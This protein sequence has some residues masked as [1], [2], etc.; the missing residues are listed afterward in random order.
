MSLLRGLNV[1]KL[2]TLGVELAGIH[3]PYARIHSSIFGKASYR[4]ILDAVTGRQG[5]T[6]RKAVQALS[7]V[8][9]EID[10]LMAEI[11]AVS[12]ADC[13]TRGGVY[14]RDTLGE[15]GSTLRETIRELR[16]ICE[17]LADDEP[18][19]RQVVGGEFS[20]F[21]QDKVKYD[22]RK[23]QLERLGTRLNKLFSTY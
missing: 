16:Q 23:T 1:T 5:T 2:I 18:D 14:L 11:S 15:Y 3:R 22:D 21:S 12:E 17:N 10:G 9:S 7:V 6:Y 20:R 13:P 4:L 19:Y 8:D